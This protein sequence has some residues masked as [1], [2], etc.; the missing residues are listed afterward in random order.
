MK[1]LIPFL[2]IIIFFLSAPKQILAQEIYVQ[3]SNQEIY[4][5]LDELASEHYIKLNSCIKPYS[6]S[7]IAGKLYDA[8]EDETLMSKR[9]KDKL[10][11]Y[12]LD[13]G[14][15]KQEFIGSDFY[16]SNFLNFKNQPQNKKKVDMF[17]YGDSTFQISINPIISLHYNITDNTNIYKRSNGAEAHACFGK[18]WGF[19]VSLRDNYFSEDINNEKFLIQDQGIV[20]KSNS[21]G[22][23]EGEQIHAGVS[24]SWDW[25]SVGIIKDHINWGDNYHGANIIS[26][27]AP[28]FARINLNLKPTKWFELNYFHAWLVSNIIDSTRSWQLNN[29]TRTVMHEKYMAANMFTFKPFKNFH[30]SAGNSIIYSDIGIHPAYLI[31]VMFFKAAD[32]SINGKS[33][34][35]GQ[36]SQMFFNISSR[37]IKHV[38]L[39][40]SLFVDEISLGRMWDDSLHSNFISWKVGVNLSNIIP[41]TS[42]G[43]EYTRT[44]PIVYKHYIPTTTFATNDFV[45]GSYLK[46]NVQEFFININYQPH[47]RWNINTS[48]TSIQKGPDYEDDRTN[49][50]ELGLPFIDYIQWSYNAFELKTSYTVMH[51][52]YF[53]LGV[54]YTNA[55][56]NAVGIYAPAYISGQQWN[57]FSGLLLG[58]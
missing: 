45:L 54:R 22:S 21:D 28:S 25:G 50:N 8:K 43:F 9:M 39:Y 55:S 48:F 13:Y 58:F 52:T 17:Y 11:F 34:H 30:I 51:N 33:N 49:H 7:F 10:Y 46:D 56:K 47:F 35:T 3:I 31:P 23:R 36:N 15:E 53:S 57:L 24:Y 19:Y 4:L 14:K 6:R 5:F 40:S 18:H 42:I 26:D 41:N 2:L 37:Q 44:N 29:G 32:H 20:L 27:R 12:L 16:F 1:K 38:H